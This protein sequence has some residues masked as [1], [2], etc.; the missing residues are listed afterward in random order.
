MVKEKVKR[1]SGELLQAQTNCNNHSWFP[2]IKTLKYEKTKQN[3]CAFFAS[4]RLKHLG[5]LAARQNKQCTNQGLS[6]ISCVKI[7]LRYSSRPLVGTQQPLVWLIVI[8]KSKLY[9]IF[10]MEDMKR[11]VPFLISKVHEIRRFEPRIRRQDQFCS[12]LK[13]IAIFVIN[14]CQDFK[15]KVRATGGQRLSK[16]IVMKQFTS[17]VSSP[18][19]IW[20]LWTYRGVEKN[21]F[22]VVLP[23][24]WNT[25]QFS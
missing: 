16:Q 3:C 18:G 13:Y 15:G 17:F 19:N 9:T 6:R 20:I 14:I 7:T 1:L 10:H 21:D 12:D 11:T 22:E 8:C 23:T 2:F 4:S 24:C 5:H 25:F